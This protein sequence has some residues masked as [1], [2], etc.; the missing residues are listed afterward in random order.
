MPDPRF[1]RRSFIQTAGLVALA[2]T[3]GNAAPLPTAKPQ[4]APKLVEPTLPQGAYAQLGSS[5][6]R[7]LYAAGRLKFS[8]DGKFILARESHFAAIWD[9]ATGLKKFVAP[10][11]FGVTCYDEIWNPDNTITIADMEAD[12]QYSVRQYDPSGKRLFASAF[13]FPGARNLRLSPRGD[14]IIIVDVDDIWC[15]SFPK[16]EK[17]WSRSRKD[18]EQKKEEHVYNG[19]NLLISPDGTQLA[20][21]I[22]Q[23][24][25]LMGVEGLCHGMV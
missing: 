3:D 15:Y 2:P 17:I 11:E 23:S 4:L 20:R 16:R 7:G 18:Q 1:S 10:H 24:L 19:E 8:F 6:F 9:V 21:I 25:G 14:R 5:R 22:H 12:N 13:K